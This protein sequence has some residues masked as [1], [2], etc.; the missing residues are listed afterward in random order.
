MIGPLHIL[1]ELLV[2]REH[3]LAVYRMVSAESGIH[4]IERSVA[5]VFKRLI[6][7]FGLFHAHQCFVQQTSS[8]FHQNIYKK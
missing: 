5:E 3:F 2:E 8:E 6:K 4:K 1:I 7:Y